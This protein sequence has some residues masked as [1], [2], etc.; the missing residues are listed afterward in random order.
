M[1][2]DCCPCE[3]RPFVWSRRLNLITLSSSS[4]NREKKLLL[5]TELVKKTQLPFS[6]MPLSSYFLAFNADFKKNIVKG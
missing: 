1:Q 6:A 5:K 4:L 2:Q 3:E